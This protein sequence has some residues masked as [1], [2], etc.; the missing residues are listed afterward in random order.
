[1]KKVA[2]Y[3]N[4][5]DYAHIIGGRVT[6]GSH[7]GKT[8]VV[9]SYD[10]R[11]SVKSGK[12]SWQVFLYAESRLN[13]NTILQGIGNVATLLGNCLRVFPDTRETMISNR[14]YYK[15]ALQKP[16]RELSAELQKASIFNAFWHKA[17]FN[18]EVEY[19]GILPPTFD[20]STAK[21]AEKYFHVFDSDEVIKTI[22]AN[23]VADN[24]KQYNKTQ[25]PAQKVIFPTQLKENNK[26]V[27]LGKIEI[28]TDPKNYRLAKM[29]IRPDRAFTLLTDHLLPTNHP[30]SQITAYGKAKRLKIATF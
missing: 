11:H 30:H 7:T 23:T 10:G 28:R 16:M 20:P 8:D 15:Q 9:D 21:M 27:I 2:G 26:S 13:S 1:M 17:L 25:T 18:G 22:C 12:R 19:L 6:R 5:E 14:E 24:S 4:E 29:W 3:T